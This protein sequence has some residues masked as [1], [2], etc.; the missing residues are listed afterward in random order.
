[1]SEK[2]KLPVII[3]CVRA[4]TE[5]LQIHAT[6]KP[7]QP[8]IVHGFNQNLKI[9]CQLLQKKIFLSFGKALLNQNSNASVVLPLIPSES[10]FLETDDS[11]YTILEIYERAA[12]LAN[13]SFE[14]LSMRIQYN[15][16]EIFNPTTKTLI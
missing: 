12:E 1:L 5:L 13:I 2:L 16:N 4:W 3:H 9:A 6:V 14:K 7:M 15:F 10:L 11:D 8:W